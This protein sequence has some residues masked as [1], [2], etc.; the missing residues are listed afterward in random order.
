MTQLALL[1]RELF[2]QEKLTIMS[3]ALTLIHDR[4]E[5]VLIEALIRA[6]EEHIPWLDEETVADE[7]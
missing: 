3:R 2:Y 1:K 7:G 6:M 4:E 5:D